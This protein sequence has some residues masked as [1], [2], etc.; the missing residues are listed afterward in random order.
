[1]R[2]EKKLLVREAVGHLDKSSYAY[3][4]GFDRLTVGEVATLR[5]LLRSS[6]AEYHVVKNSVLDFALRECGLPELAHGTLRGPTAIVSGGN[7]PSTVA[8]SYCAFAGERGRE[9]KLTVKCGILDGQLL[10]AKD[11]LALSLLPPPAELRAGFLSLLQAPAQRL[12]AL[13]QAAPQNFLRLLRAWA[14]KST[15]EARLGNCSS[16]G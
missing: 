10:T 1:M 2:E 13:L 16:N 3:V 5:G 7:E 14:E 8:K 9:G 15:E 6:G 4:V 12:L 11:V